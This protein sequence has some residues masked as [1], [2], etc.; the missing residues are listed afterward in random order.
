MQVNHTLQNAFNSASVPVTAEFN[1]IRKN[2]KDGSFIY[3]ITLR[4]PIA[5]D[6]SKPIFINPPV[7]D[8]DFKND[9]VSC[10]NKNSLYTIDNLLTVLQALPNVITKQYRVNAG[11]SLFFLKQ[12]LEHG[13]Y[14]STLES[15]GIHPRTAQRYI[16][17][18][19]N[20]RRTTTGADTLPQTRVATADEV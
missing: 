1:A 11:E 5:F 7:C 19:Q 13:R 18:F 20:S 6:P 10:M 4:S 15:L 12:E 3:Y 2:K 8:S 14:L 16:R 9:T 17:V